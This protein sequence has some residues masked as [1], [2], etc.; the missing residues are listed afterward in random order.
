MA[1]LIPLLEKRRWRSRRVDSR[2]R[3]MRFSA[4]GWNQAHEAEAAGRAARIDNELKVGIGFSRQ[5]ENCN[6]I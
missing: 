1:E 4:F 5:M 6:N 2:G 3:T